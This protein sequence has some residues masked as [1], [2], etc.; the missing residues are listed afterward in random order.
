MQDKKSF[1]LYGSYYEQIMMLSLEERG[2]L[3]TAIYEYDRSG[4]V[5]VELSGMAAMAFSFIRSAMNRDKAEYEEKCSKNR[6]S[7]R[8]G[9]RPKKENTEEENQAEPHKDITAEEERKLLS[10]GIP[11]EYIAERRQRA[12]QV[13]T[14]KGG[15]WAQ[16]LR[17]W[18]QKDRRGIPPKPKST[19][20]NHEAEDW[21]RAKLAKQF[22]SG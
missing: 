8:Q 18:W 22:G 19:V 14:E 11:A 21:F 7:G 13:A 10:E 9:G 20:S 12:Q 3:I 17:S 1:I 15:S 2:Q 6:A 16:I 4:E 5:S